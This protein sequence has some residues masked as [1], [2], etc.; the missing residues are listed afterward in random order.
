MGQHECSR[1]LFFKEGANLNVLRPNLTFRIAKD[2][3]EKA[4]TGF[5][6]SAIYPL[7]KTAATSGW[8]ANSTRGHDVLDNIKYLRL[9][10]ELAGILEFTLT[11]SPRDNNGKPEPEHSGRFVASH[12][13]SPQTFK[14]PRSLRVLTL[15]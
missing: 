15:G 5:I 2:N 13:V 4:T 12:V 1:A 9:V 3:L 6:V 7:V 10:Q 8:Q 14:C 11:R